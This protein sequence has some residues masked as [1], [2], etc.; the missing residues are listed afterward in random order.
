M[1]RIIGPASL[2]LL[3]YTATAEPC[4]VLAL[5]GGGQ[6][7]VFQAG[8]L[9]GLTESAANG[10]TEYDIITG[11]AGGAI[12]GALLSDFA[13][14][15]E[16]QAAD[17]MKTFWEGTATQD[18]Y[19]EWMGGL[20]DGLLLEG[21]LYDDTKLKN[22]IKTEFSGVSPKRDFDFGLTDL[23]S[24]K[25]DSYTQ[26][27]ISTEAP[28]DSAMTSSLSF[29]GYFPPADA[30]GSKDYDGASVWNLIIAPGVNYCLEKTTA[31]N[32]SV[33]VLMTSGSDL[34]K[35]DASGYTSLSMLYRFIHIHFYYSAMNG[36]LRAKFAYPDVNFRYVVTPS[37]G[38]QWNLTPFSYDKA[39]IDAAFQQGVT[40]AKTAVTQGAGV[41]FE[42]L[43]QYFGL[44][45]KA[46]KRV[47]DMSFDDYLSAREAMFEGYKVAEDKE[48][49]KYFLQE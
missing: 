19:E 25:F 22:Y 46:D 36:L 9:K 14:G 44:K 39:D 31:D 1:K 8:A 49:A 38:L 32:I 13:K 3:G 24:G 33:D 45:K 2:I 41:H 20:L 17:K 34:D 11:V 4:R 35:V 21:G 26:K 16:A 48:V 18:M 27:D 40:D 15:Q 5:S 30:Y 29:A 28:L 12:N 10:E 42:D 7:S 23:L 6:S 37:K 43:V 47:E